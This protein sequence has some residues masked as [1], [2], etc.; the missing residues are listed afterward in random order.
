VRMWY[1]ANKLIQVVL[2]AGK[3]AAKIPRSGYGLF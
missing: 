1:P 2:D 3:R